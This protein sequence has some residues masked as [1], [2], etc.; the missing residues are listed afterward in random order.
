MDLDRINVIA[1]ILVCVLALVLLLWTV[2]RFRSFAP[3]M[4]I[5]ACSIGVYLVCTI[6]NTRR[7]MAA[8]YLVSFTLLL[9][10]VIVLGIWLYALLKS[11]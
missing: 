5:S 1:M 3:M 4:A 6:C 7:T 8:Y 9:G 11:E 10:S 2:K